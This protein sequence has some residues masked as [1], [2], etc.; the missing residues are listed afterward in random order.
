VSGTN[1]RKRVLIVGVGGLG[2]PAAIALGRSGEV[3]LGLADGD[4]VELS[5]LHRQLLHDMH[6]LGGSKVE[7]AAAE[8][9]RLTGTRPATLHD[10][11]IGAGNATLLGDYDFVIDA[12]D[13][14][15]TK[16]FL[17][18]AAVRLGVALCSAGVVG[19]TGQLLT[20]LPGASAC[21]RCVF[22]EAPAAEEPSCRA[23]GILGPAAG[24]IGALAAL[25]AIKFATGSGTL[26]ADRLL[27]FDFR[28]AR[29]GEIAV[30]R[31]DDC[32]TC[33]AR[34]GQASEREER[35]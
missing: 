32:I 21:L 15:D 20:V 9:A 26:A 8:L 33:G 35:I 22:P 23:A 7:S 14:A 3:E 11:P 12:T 17:N 30:A 16:F 13:G 25:E 18:D 5:N 2:S 34:A 29:F 31:R 6:G 19:F 1:K 24:M 10:E 28:S 27:H 4:S